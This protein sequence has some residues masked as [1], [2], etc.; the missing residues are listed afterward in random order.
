MHSAIRHR[1]LCC[2]TLHTGK[3][4]VLRF[5]LVVDETTKNIAALSSTHVG[6]VLTMPSSTSSTPPA[7]VCDAILARCMA[8]YAWFFPIV[9][10]FVQD[11]SRTH[12]EEGVPEIVKPPLAQKARAVYHTSAF[13]RS[14][15]LWSHRRHE[16]RITFPLRVP[17]LHPPR[18]VTASNTKS[19]I[20]EVV[21]HGNGS[22]YKYRSHSQHLHRPWFDPAWPQNRNRARGLHDSSSPL[23]AATSNPREDAPS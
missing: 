8:L 23:V 12:T 17:L 5:P 10:S 9:A 11:V 4:L 20:D 22:S 14:R 15:E 7:A 3:T 18:R 6:R 13:H 2:T 1:H 16:I 21:L 19:V